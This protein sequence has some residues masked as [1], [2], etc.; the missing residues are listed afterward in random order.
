MPRWHR[1]PEVPRPVSLL[2]GCFIA[3]VALLLAGS[4][5]SAKLT[6]PRAY[7]GSQPRTLDDLL[8]R[9]KLELPPCDVSGLRYYSNSDLSGDLSMTFTLPDECLGKFLQSLG[10]SESDK[11]NLPG[12]SVGISSLT[13]E[14]L[15]WPIDRAKMYEEYDTRNSDTT[16]FRIVVDRTGRQPIVYLAGSRS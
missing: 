13:I 15:G 12:S 14:Q 9:F 10:A 8:H 16:S 2:H 5:C 4:S 1:C 3:G 6:D 11:T 7:P